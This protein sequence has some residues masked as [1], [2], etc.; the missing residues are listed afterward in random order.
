VAERVS[1]DVMQVRISA[2]AR[3]GHEVVEYAE[4]KVRSLVRYA[5]EPLL[6]AR[7]RLTVHANAAVTRPVVAQGNLDLNGRPVRAQV[8]AATAYE[9]VDALQD[10]LRRRLSRMARDWS[11]LRGGRAA[12]AAQRLRRTSGPAVRPEYVPRPAGE[13]EVVRRKTFAPA[14]STVDE[15]VFEMELMDFDFY[16][17]TEAG[18]GQHSVLYQVGDSLRMAQVYPEQD[19]V[20]PSSVPVEISTRPAPQLSQAEAERRLDLSGQPFLF[21]VDPE[22]CQACVLYHR[23]DGHYGLLTA[24]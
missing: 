7:V 14:S 8:S 1:A 24:T 13:R 22:R 19:R 15:A 21:F 10:V 18:G 3:L 20:T 9:A 16:L 2:P 17:F 23:Y 4:A 5:H 6:R 12:D 11:A